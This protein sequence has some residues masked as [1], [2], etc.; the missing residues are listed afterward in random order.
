MTVLIDTN[1]ALDWLLQ[2]ESFYE[3]AQLIIRA[4]EQGELLGLVSAS[5]IT[6]IFFLSKR[7]LRND[8]SARIVLSKLL[9]VVKIA[10]VDGS[11]IRDAFNLKW[12][13]FEDSV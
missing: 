4:V 12:A 5:A 3:N 11:I 8:E 2:R 13:D 1:V 9:K 10:A 6:D 7:A